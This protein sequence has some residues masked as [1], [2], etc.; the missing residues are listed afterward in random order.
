MSSARIARSWLLVVASSF[1]GGAVSNW[2]LDRARGAE[3]SPRGG[4]SVP[5]PPSPV[6][7]STPPTVMTVPL[8]GLEFRTPEG[9]KLAR[10]YAHD[11]GALFT[12]FND[13]GA[14]VA[15][16]GADEDERGGRL[17]LNTPEGGR[18]VLGLGRAA[19]GLV[20][21]FAREDPEQFMARLGV[22]DGGRGGVLTLWDSRRLGL[23]LLTQHIER[24][25][26]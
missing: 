16:L 15:T 25:S 26:H 9:R 1:V 13:V 5:R 12:V 19:G 23:G 14:A 21:I 3:A 2:A 11:R 18:A 24:M 6:D 8:G 10:L 17:A 20:G 4:V 22:V 7:K